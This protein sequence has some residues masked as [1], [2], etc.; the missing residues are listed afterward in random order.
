LIDAAFPASDARIAAPQLGVGDWAHVEPLGLLCLTRRTWQ[1]AAADR[2]IQSLKDAAEVLDMDAETQRQEYF[3]EF[4]AYW[5]QRVTHKSPVFMTLVS[6]VA[7]NRELFYHRQT[8]RDRVLLAED[9]EALVRW[10]AHSGVKVEPRSLLRTQL[11]WLPQPWTPREFPEFS[12]DVR[13]AATPVDLTPYLGVGESLPVLFGA[14]TSTG[15]VFVGT[16]LPGVPRASFRK[17]GFRDPAKV[18]GALLASMSASLRVTRCR[19]ERV[20]R[21]WVYGR[22]RDPAQARLATKKIG[23]V[24]CGALGSS[25]ARLLVQMGV[26][27]WLLVDGD[28][29]S[30]PNTA[31]HLLGNPYIHVNKAE[32]LCG[33]LL[34]DFP[35]LEPIETF[36]IDLRH[37]TDQQRSALS[38][39]N[40]IVSAGISWTGDLLL[41]QWRRSWT[42]RPVHVCAW[43]EEFALAGH[44]VALVGEDTLR[45]QFSADG[46]PDFRLTTWP[47]SVTTQIL[48]AGCGNLFQPHGAV[49][50][51]NS[52]SLAA[53]LVLDILI[54]E[55]RA[56]C[57]RVWLGDRARLA[58][59]GGTAAPQFDMSHTRR[60]F[61]WAT[62]TD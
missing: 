17:G 61:P 18:H 34:R 30:A 27:G 47:A 45:S 35:H 38:Q 19:V 49:D 28:V 50:L 23:L 54:G 24:G 31:R 58:Q 59:L 14:P 44:A 21:A 3:A 51:I 48:E 15:P 4:G 13:S 25:I 52:A 57:R 20:D 11:I 39:C 22:D 5:T 29:L 7:G 41:D 6:P 60:E 12:K 16:D 42:H 9:R 32:A 53:Q 43:V 1:G 26:G 62:G 36:P 46:D 8:D 37:L 55:A 33:Q 10:L 2:V 56:S 40:V